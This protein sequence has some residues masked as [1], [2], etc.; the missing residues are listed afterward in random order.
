MEDKEVGRHVFSFNPQDNGGESLNLI[1]IFR[2]TEEGDIYTNQELILQSY[3][4][5][6]SFDLSGAAFTPDNLRALAN[7]MESEEVVMRAEFK[8]SEA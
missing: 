6:A 3:F 2:E 5:S 4:N 7:E 1:T 8:K